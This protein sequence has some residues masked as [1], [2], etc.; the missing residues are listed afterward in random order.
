MSD[1]LHRTVVP[2]NAGAFERAVE[3][4]NAA[5]RPLPATIL[6]G[7]DDPY[8][9]PDALLPF[10]ARKKG[11][12]VWDDDWTLDKQRRVIATEAARKRLVGLPEAI[13]AYVELYDWARVHRIEDAPQ[14]F[15]LIDEDEDANRAW[16]DGLPELRIYPFF[17]PGDDAG[18]FLDADFLGGDFLVDDGAESGFRATF[19]KDGAEADIGLLDRT[20]PVDVDGG[21]IRLALPG[22]A[23]VGE[24]FLDDGFFGIDFLEPD[25]AGRTV[26]ISRGTIGR[27]AVAPGLRP[28]TATPELVSKPRVDAA[29]FYLDV[30]TLDDGFLGAAGDGSATY[31]RY[32]LY[33]P[34]AGAVR[35]AAA[36]GGYLDADRL[37]LPDFTLIVHVEIIGAAGVDETF[38]DADFLDDGFFTPDGP[39]RLDRLIEAIDAGSAA[40]DTVL[41]NTN[42]HRLIALGDAPPLDGTYRL[43]QYIKD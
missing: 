2:S 15:F 23:D 30:D 41:L 5:R 27:N 6:W 16:L 7:L 29:N 11:C 21:E 1:D 12:R 39:D 25:P 32:R 38:C 42:V 20:A 8:R 35:V 4:V 36:P 43:G 40:R 22:F 10:L 19:F 18:L 26:V 13:R 33:D 28:V 9:C 24:M 31:W 34:D 17:K 3:E 14:D 37:G